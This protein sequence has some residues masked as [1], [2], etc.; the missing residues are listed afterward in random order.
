MTIALQ[1][2]PVLAPNLRL[3]TDRVSGEPVL[4]YPEGVLELNATAHEIIR[5]CDGATTVE[6]MV[7]ELTREY[8]APIEEVRADVLECLRELSGRNFILSQP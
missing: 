6:A 1:T 2:R 7:A 4:L 5:R 3:Q 8:D